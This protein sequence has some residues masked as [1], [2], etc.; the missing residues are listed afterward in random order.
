MGI[1]VISTAKDIAAAVAIYVDLFNLNDVKKAPLIAPPVPIRPARNPD[2]PPPIMLFFLV[3]F[4]EIVS[5]QKARTYTSK[6]NPRINFKRG[7]EI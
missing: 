5:F 3:G 6:N 7:W 1:L 4:T 2:K